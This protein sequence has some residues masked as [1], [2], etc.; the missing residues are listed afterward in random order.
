MKGIERQVDIAARFGI[1]WQSVSM[2]QRGKMYAASSKVSYWTADED[3][4]IREAIELGYNFTRMA[5]HVGRSASAVSG[6]A[7]RLGLTSGQPRT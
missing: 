5:T 3:A 6:R 7:Y 2:I 4:K 1:S